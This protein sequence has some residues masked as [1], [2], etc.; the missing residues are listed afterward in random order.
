MPFRLQARAGCKGLVEAQAYHLIGSVDR[1]A[2]VRP[3]LGHEHPV[4]AEI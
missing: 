3:M 2:C 1:T 4:A